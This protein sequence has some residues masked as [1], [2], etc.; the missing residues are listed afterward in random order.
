M[1]NNSIDVAFKSDSLILPNPE[2][3]DSKYTI[4]VLPNIELPDDSLADTDLRDHD[5]IDN[6]MYVYYGSHN[7]N[8]GSYGPEII[9]IGSVLSCAP[10]LLTIFCV[11]LKKNQKRGKSY[12]TSYF[13][14]PHSYESK[15]FC[16]ISVQKGMILNYMLPVS[17]LIIMTT[18]YSLSGIR[19]INMELSKLEFNSSAES[20]NALRNELEMLKDKRDDDIDEEI[21]GLRES[22]TCLKLLCV[23]QTGYD[24]V[25]F[26]VVLA[27][28]NINDGNGMSLIYAFTSCLLNWYIFIRRKSLMPTI[29]SIPDV[30]DDQVVQTEENKNITNT[31]ASVS[32]RGSSDSMPLLNSESCTEMRELR[33]DHISTI[34]N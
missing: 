31:S 26:V 19:K 1:S 14:I 25:W 23:I 12:E 17:I 2:S 16:F 18:L 29:N 6:I 32:R 4:D 5:F 34:S 28:E 13:I 8:A 7:R 20:I 10:Q 30:I 9:I 27:L 21:V 11:L 3:I 15:R 33:L 22:K 24:I